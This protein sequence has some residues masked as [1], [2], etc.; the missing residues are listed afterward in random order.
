MELI[1]PASQTTPKD[2]RR[3]RVVESG[4]WKVTYFV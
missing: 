1:D 3:R 4:K 2:D